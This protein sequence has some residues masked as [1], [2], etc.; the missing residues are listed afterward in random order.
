VISEPFG[1]LEVSAGRLASSRRAPGR[2]R[3]GRRPTPTATAAVCGTRRWTGRSSEIPHGTPP[4]LSRCR[5]SFR[6]EVS[7]F[8]CEG[9]AVGSAVLGRSQ[10]I[11]RI[12]APQG[13]HQSSA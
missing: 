9:A 1:S 2:K 8:E 12:R 11:A 4:P 10:G 6:L 3:R 7:V 5:Q 13:G